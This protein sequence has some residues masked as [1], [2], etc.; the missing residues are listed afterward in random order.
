MTTK[1]LPQCDID[2]YRVPGENKGY[3]SFKQ[4]NQELHA[5]RSFFEDKTQC[6]VAY[7]NSAKCSIALW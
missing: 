3:D 7:W 1:Y 6:G 4:I 5:H 2:F